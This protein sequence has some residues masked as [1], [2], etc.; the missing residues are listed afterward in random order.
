MDKGNPVTRQELEAALE[1]F[2][3]RIERRMDEKLAAQDQRFEGRM[4]TLEQRMK[5]HVA[6]C[7][8]QLETRLLQAFYGF[9]E[10]NN[11][12]SEQMETSA[13]A[14]SNRVSTLESRMLGVE[15]RL[16]MPPAA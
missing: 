7:I 13:T 8:H 9:A 2:E 12:R 14:L 10:S 11:R 16:N 5:E 1:A 15:K 6:E 4:D 3:Q